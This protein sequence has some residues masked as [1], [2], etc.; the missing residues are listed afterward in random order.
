MKTG[1]QVKSRKAMKQKSSSSVDRLCGKEIS[2]EYPII[3][4]QVKFL[5]GKVLTII[6]ATLSDERQLRAV[7]SL[8]SRTFS[9]QL[10]NIAQICY[11]EVQMMSRDAVNEIVGDVD[12]I[13]REAEVIGN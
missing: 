6:E 8:I 11:P 4:A 1:S 13:E 2:L 7:K 3:E 5:Q 9:E 12:K 10:T